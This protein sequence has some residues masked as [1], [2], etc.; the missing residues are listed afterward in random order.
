MN[1]INVNRK[2]GS[3]ERMAKKFFQ[4]WTN[5]EFERVPRSGGLRWK[6]VDNIT[7][8]LICTEPNIAFHILNL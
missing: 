4:E 6:K 1:R 2:G 5:W 3:G 7:G 8:D